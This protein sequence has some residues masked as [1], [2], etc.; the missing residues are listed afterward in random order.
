[1]LAFSVV[2]LAEP[3]DPCMAREV[4]TGGSEHRHRLVVL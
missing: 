1:M 3:A 2:F 4:V